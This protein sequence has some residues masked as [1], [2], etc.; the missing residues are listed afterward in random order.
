MRST[1]F[2]LVEVLVAL[3]LLT[4][5]LVPAFIQASHAVTLAGSVRNS[6]IAS[7][8]AQEGAEAVRAIRDA[9]WLAG[10]SFDTG[11]DSCAGGCRVA[12]DGDA[13]ISGA[14]ANQ[15]LKLDSA[16]GLYQ[17][18]SGTDTLF[19]RT[20][21]ITQES[22]YHLKAVVTVSWTER[23]GTRQL[24]LEYHLYDWLK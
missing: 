8:L 19:S 15:P 16:T 3:A 17:Y 11:L 7:N 9:N 6:L 1:G 2:T 21:V 24:A 12:F 20:V 18:V 13:L 5:G 4:I 23:T 22:A 10:D 14:G